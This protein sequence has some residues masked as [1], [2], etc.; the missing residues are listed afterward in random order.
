MLP[1]EIEQAEFIP[2]WWNDPHS[3]SAIPALI[4]ASTLIRSL[5]PNRRLRMLKGRNRH[6]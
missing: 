2:D 6:A 1:D 5:L 3:T 4:S